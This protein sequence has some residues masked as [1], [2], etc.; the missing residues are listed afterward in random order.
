MKVCPLRM[1]ALE[2]SPQAV[3]NTGNADQIVEEATNTAFDGEKMLRETIGCLGP[4]CAWWS[5]DSC[6]LADLRFLYWIKEAL[7]ALDLTIYNKET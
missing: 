5:S 7:A 6:A 4:D 1:M 2:S 3:R